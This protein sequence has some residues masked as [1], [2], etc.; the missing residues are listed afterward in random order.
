MNSAVLDLVALNDSNEVWSWYGD[1]SVALQAAGAVITGT[2]LSGSA[3]VQVSSSASAFIRATPG[4]APAQV[5]L[6]ATGSLIYGVT[7]SGKADLRLTSSANGTRWV[8]GQ[9]LAQILFQAIGDGQV[10]GPAS[11]SFIIQVASNLV[12]RV[13]PAIRGEGVSRVVLSTALQAQAAKPI[14]LEGEPAGV[15]LASIATPYLSIRSASGAASLQLL[16]DGDSRLG[17]KLQ[18]E[19]LPAELSLY[20]R[21]EL[22]FRHYVYASGS[23]EVVIASTAARYGIPTLPSSYVAAPTSRALRVESEQRRFIVPAERRL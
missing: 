14:W 20:T 17:G 4:F 8:M 6:A 12:E 22:G 10:A 16:A 13:T 9:S 5:A 7:G 2:T 21:G 3:S 19:P 1:A 18:L 15:V 23:A 11:A